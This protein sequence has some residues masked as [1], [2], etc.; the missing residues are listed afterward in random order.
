MKEIYKAIR[1]F[2][3]FLRS[4]YFIIPVSMY[5]LLMLPKIL[6]DFTVTTSPVYTLVREHSTIKVDNIDTQTYFKYA[7]YSE[8]FNPKQF[9]TI[10]TESNVFSTVKAGIPGV[11]RIDTTDN[12]KAI[13]SSI[14]ILLQV[15]ELET[16][17]YK[18]RG[19]NTKVQFIYNDIEVFM[20]IKEK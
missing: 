18:I 9:E 3:L 11:Y 12:N 19:R 13:I 20:I 5:I 10:T 17:T 1:Y 8:N 16:G 7:E 6:T 15:H 2:H 14:K 4:K